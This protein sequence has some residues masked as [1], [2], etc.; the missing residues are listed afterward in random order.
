MVLTFPRL[1]IAGLTLMST[2]AACANE[3]TPAVG[4]APEPTQTERGQYVAQ[5][6]DCIACHTAKGAAPMSGSAPPATAHCPC[7]R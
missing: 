5:L 4:Y 6:G 3:P 7:A 2:F 1:A